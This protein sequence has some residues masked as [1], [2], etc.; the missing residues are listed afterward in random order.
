[1]LTTQ[2]H[3]RGRDM[4]RNGLPRLATDARKGLYRIGEMA[5]GGAGMTDVIYK[6]PCH[7]GQELGA[8]V[9]RLRIVGRADDVL[10]RTIIV[11]EDPTD[12]PDKITGRRKS[13]GV[14]PCRECDPP[15]PGTIPPV[16]SG[17]AEGRK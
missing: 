16:R 7:A 4:A 12:T 9:L 13:Y 5:S 8:K 17:Q 3:L 15:P 2:M 14:R 1:M 11:M 10:Y 6:C